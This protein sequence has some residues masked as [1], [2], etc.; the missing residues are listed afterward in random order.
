MVTE[1]NYSSWSQVWESDELT[2]ANRLTRNSTFT[3]NER[4]AII[5]DGEYIVIVNVSN[6]NI[7][8]E[9]TVDSTIDDDSYKSS[10]VYGK[11][12]CVI[13]NSEEDI[14]VY[15]DGSLI[16]TLSVDGGTDSFKG[17]LISHTGKYI[18]ALYNTTIYKLRCFQGV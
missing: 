7:S 1:G 15:K 8:S 14:L 18:I 6:G 17:V 10:S 2:N 9:F 5:C 16:D 13:D 12:W 4:Q 3:D 11:Y